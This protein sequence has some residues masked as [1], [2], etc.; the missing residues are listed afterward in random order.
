ML[1]GA[2]QIGRHIVQPALTF[3]FL[4][5]L[6]IADRD[7]LRAQQ[8]AAETGDSRVRAASVD[9]NDPAALALLFQEADVVVSTVGPYYRFG[10]IVLQAAIKAQYHYIDVWVVLQE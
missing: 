8:C 4:S 9:A 1:G 6:V 3:P 10:A 2:G 7:E 5:S